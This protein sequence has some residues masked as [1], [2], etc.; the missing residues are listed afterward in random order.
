MGVRRVFNAWRY[1]MQGLAAAMRYE[2]AFRQELILAIVL[3]PMAFWLGRNLL[4]VALL[5]VVVFV[6]LITELLNSALEAL[7]DSVSMELNPLI[8]RAKDI[9]SA[10]VWLSLMML[11]VVWVCVALDRYASSWIRW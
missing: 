10:A 7:A 3:V 1:S 5:L 9:G 8:G 2:A 11:V 6:M 4:E